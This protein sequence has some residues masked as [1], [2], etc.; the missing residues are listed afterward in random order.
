MARVNVYTVRRWWSYRLAYRWQV[1]DRNGNCLAASAK[2]YASLGALH[3]DV[4]AII[5]ALHEASKTCVPIHE[6]KPR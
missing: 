3:D 2:D 4:C 1:V 6:G 5:V